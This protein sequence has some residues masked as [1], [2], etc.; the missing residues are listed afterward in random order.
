MKQA[1]NLKIHLS[2]AKNS[3]KCYKN[4]INV[5]IIWGKIIWGYR[6][7]ENQIDIFETVLLIMQSV[8][9][10]NIVFV[11]GQGKHACVKFITSVRRDLS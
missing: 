2:T 9:S 6:L 11:S 4:C 7:L 5:I 3:K 1:S 8:L 10:L